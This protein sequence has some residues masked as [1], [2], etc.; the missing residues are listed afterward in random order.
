MTNQKYKNL[1]LREFD[2][3]AEKRLSILLSLILYISLLSSRV[4]DARLN[5]AGGVVGKRRALVGILSCLILAVELVYILYELSV[6]QMKR[7]LL[8]ADSRAF[9]AVG[10]ASGNVEGSYDVEH[11]LLK[12]V[13]SRLLGDT[14]GIVVEY[15]LFAGAG[16]TYV[17][18]GIAA[19]TS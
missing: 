18:A 17:P 10:T 19:D 8:R 3:A 12:R 9:S 2:A 16:G 7:Y 15:A 14:G 6:E 13:G 4:N 5:V 11:I 1:T